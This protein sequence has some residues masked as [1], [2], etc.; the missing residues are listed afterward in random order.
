MPI[1][2][3]IYEDDPSKNRTID[4][5]TGF[6]LQKQQS[7]SLSHSISFFIYNSF[8]EYISLDAE[9]YPIYTDEQREQ[10]ISHIYYMIHFIHRN[11]NFNITPTKK[12]IEDLIVGYGTAYRKFEREYGYIENVTVKF[13]DRALEQLQAMGGG[14][15]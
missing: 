12:M 11:N 6:Y 9:S 7:H 1:I 4:T 8:E 5:D 3:E 14:N 2:N 10:K 15:V 13:S